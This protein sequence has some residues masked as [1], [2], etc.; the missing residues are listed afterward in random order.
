MTFVR[1]AIA[2]M[3]DAA[4]Q[5][6]LTYA[7]IPL[8]LT[9]LAQARVS[10]ESFAALWLAIAKELDDEFFGLDSRRM[11]VGSFA[12]MTRSALTAASL[13]P[14]LRRALRA[15]A[16]FLDE[17]GG[18]LRIHAAASADQPT[19]FP[20]P[21]TASTG[22][23][24]IT[25]RN[26]IE[27]ASARLFADETLLVLVNGLMCWL[28]GRRVALNGV[29][30]A[31]PR[32]AHAAEHALMFTPELRYDATATVLRFDAR[33]LAAPV[34]QTPA[35]ARIFL[36]DS[37]QTIF[38]KYRAVDSW[39]ARLQRR[40]RQDLAQPPLLEQVAADWQVAPSTLRRR[41][42]AEGS[43]FQS[44]KDGLR[45]DCAIQLLCHGDMSVSEIAAA[46]GFQEPSAFHRAF[47]K[48]SGGAQP[49]AYRGGR[50]GG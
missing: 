28:I 21:A 34:V 11:K 45:H 37:P 9:A 24:V 3:D 38:V 47:K 6:V 31:H 20:A 35:S 8:E 43:S 10:A 32:P 30:F 26:R 50:R 13:G 42:D 46:L 49:G 18:E 39:T 44:I 2:A 22:E 15:L 14:A 5:R 19:L 23:A 40:L 48:W 1:A 27:S 41:L 12:L 17:V 29:D 36:R 7:A 33:L 16:L 4:A 25:I